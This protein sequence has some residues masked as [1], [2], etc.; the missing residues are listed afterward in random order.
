MKTMVKKMISWRKI[1]AYGFMVTVVAATNMACSEKKDS[2]QRSYSRGGRVSINMNGGINPNTGGRCASVDFS[3]WGQIYNG[4]N[5]Q[6][7]LS[8]FLGGASVSGVDGRIGYNC[9]GMYLRGSLSSRRFEI[10]IWDEQASRTGQGIS[11]SAEVVSQ[12]VSGSY[13]EFVLKDDKGEIY[14][15]GQKYDD[16]YTYGQ[17]SYASGTYGT[18]TLGDFFLNSSYL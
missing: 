8:D 1:I 14:F 4:S 5:M 7:V 18:R 2:G 10:L 3:V 12:N 13:V 9:T 15:R 16:G 11:W 17:V 6:N